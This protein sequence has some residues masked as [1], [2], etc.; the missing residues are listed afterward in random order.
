MTKN[1]VHFDPRLVT[2]R[3]EKKSHVNTR[4]LSICILSYRSN[5]FCGGQGVYVKYLSKA[6]RDLGH[7]VEVISGE[8]YPDLDRDIGFVPLPGM[9][10]YGYNRVIDAIKERKIKGFIDLYELISYNTGGFPE[11]LTFG[12][13]A[14]SFLG[15][16]REKKYDIIHDNQSLSYGLL[17]LTSKYP[18][19]STIHHP[20]TRDLRLAL[21]HEKDF[22]LRLLIKRWHSFLKMQKRVAP[23]LPFII[24]VSKA[25]KKDIIEDFKVQPDKVHV[26]YN[27]VDIEK[28]RPLT[29]LEPVKDSIIATASADVPLKGLNYLIEA[30][31]LVRERFPNISL[32][33]VG[34]PKKQGDTEKLIQKLRLQDRVSFVSG[35]TDEELVREY[36]RAT[37]AVVPSL[38]EGFG[39][40][41][42]EAMACG[43][44]VISTTGGAL[45]EVVGNAGLLVPPG[46]PRQLANGI[47]YLL[48]NSGLQ[49]ELGTK[50]RTRTVEMFNWEAAAENTV[51]VYKKA[52]E[53]YAHS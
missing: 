6:L 44:P 18:V 11:P 21:T 12:L 39:L 25:S 29:E 9:N 34:K 2:Y 23:R 42:A 36:A 27:G 24:T 16:K 32:R 43:K 14:A 38:Y 10:F 37:I 15:R 51:E 53:H 49:K 5:P 8:P 7:R 22:F 50:A 26:V 4:P 17:K 1:P 52:I 41:A 35:I 46:D 40:P 20:I 47:C 3:L 48:S 31:S 45:S 28:F 13:R 33:V 19:V 30:I